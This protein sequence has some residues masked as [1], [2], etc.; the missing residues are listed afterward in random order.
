MK[1]LLNYEVEGLNPDD[2]N[3][4]IYKYELIKD[5][6]YPNMS[7]DQSLVKSVPNWIRVTYEGD[8]SDCGELLNILAGIEFTPSEYEYTDWRYEG[9]VVDT[10]FTGNI[11]YENIIEGE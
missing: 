7:I 1:A 11:K 3:L 2:R 4:L 9:T 5:K 6:V 10:V 8:V